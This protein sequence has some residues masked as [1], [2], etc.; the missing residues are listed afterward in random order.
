[1]SPKGWVLGGTDTM[2]QVENLRVP[3]GLWSTVS[4]SHWRAELCPVSPMQKKRQR[5]EVTL[6]EPQDMEKLGAEPRSTQQLRR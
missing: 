2:G 1:M 5:E 6:S 4:G 3:G